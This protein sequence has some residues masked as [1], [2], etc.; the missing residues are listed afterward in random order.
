[1]TTTYRHSASF[2]DL[3]TLLTGELFLPQDAD[4]EQ[5]RQLWNGRVKTQPA[6]IA[7]CLTVQDV[8]H[9][10]RW[11]RSHNLPLSVRGGG[12]EIFGRSL[13]GNGVVIDLSQMKAVTVDPNKRT[14]QIQA[15]ATA[16]D[17]IEAAQQYGLATAT[18]TIF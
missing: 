3:A 2:N 10:I 13:L 6:A 18:G 16:G 15:G 11:T 1:M 9:T 5:V 8:I 4:Y 12:H 7:R 14:A 17:L